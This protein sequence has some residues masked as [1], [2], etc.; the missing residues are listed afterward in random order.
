[1]TPLLGVGAALE[2]FTDQRAAN[3]V[4]L[5]ATTDS[6]AS[7]GLPPSARLRSAFDSWERHVGKGSAEVLGFLAEILFWF[8]LEL[9]LYPTGA[10][11]IRVVSLNRWKAAP[12]GSSIVGASRQTG[13]TEVS[14]NLT[15]ALGVVAWLALL[16]SLAIWR[17]S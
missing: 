1:M 6:G 2:K 13:V 7:S 17:A 5:D 4:L 9:I 10:L 3:A 14:V 15:I 11:I 16:V 12:W 8:F